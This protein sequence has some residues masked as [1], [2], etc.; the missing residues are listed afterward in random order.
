MNDDDTITLG[1]DEWTVADLR[2]SLSALI[3]YITRD[4]TDTNPCTCVTCW[5]LFGD[6][7]NIGP[8]SSF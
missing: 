3:D 8:D 1:D 5:Y 2:R 6:A 7:E 4:C